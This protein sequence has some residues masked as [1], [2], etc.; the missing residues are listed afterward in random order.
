MGLDDELGT[1]EVGKVADLV[2]V[3]GDPADVRGLPTRIE[4]VYQAGRQV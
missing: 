1:V 3:S 4:A 2:V